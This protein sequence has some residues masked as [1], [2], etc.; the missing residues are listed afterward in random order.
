LQKP[1]EFNRQ[2]GPLFKAWL[3]KKYRFT[4]DKD[5][6]KKHNRGLIFLGL[7]EEGLREFANSLGCGLTKRPDF[8]A[9]NKGRYVIG[10]AKFLGT[11]GG[12]QNRAFDDAISLAS[13]SFK[14]AVTVAILDGI[15]WI[16]DSGQMS[17]MLNNFSGNALTAL[18]LDRLLSSL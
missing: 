13:R 9:K 10:E 15:I 7:G 17:K 3:R 16:P 18:L 8:V 2:M 12:N 5:T 11:E 1:P 6:F 4:E 14:N